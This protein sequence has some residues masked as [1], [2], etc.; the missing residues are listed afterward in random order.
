MRYENAL[1]YIV[2]SWTAGLAICVSL[3]VDT[4]YLA[5][6][7]GE[8]IWVRVIDIPLILALSYGIYRR[9]RFSAIVMFL[10]ITSTY[11]HRWMA[12]GGPAELTLTVATGFIFF[13]G[14]RATLAVHRERSREQPA[15]PQL[16]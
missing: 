13:Q 4:A 2:I 10:V 5:L 12:V 7:V 8:M 1:K 11:F 9:Q 14:V 15:E 16:S 6:A 3:L